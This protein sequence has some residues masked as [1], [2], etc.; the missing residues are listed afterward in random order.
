MGFF[1]RKS[2]KQDAAGKGNTP[3]SRPAEAPAPQPKTI[4][5]R[6]LGREGAGQS[7]LLQAL[8]KHAGRQ[9]AVR[10]LEDGY[11]L[12]WKGAE[13]CIRET[14]F[15][16]LQEEP[17]PQAGL[18]YLVVGL[19]EGPVDLEEEL[20]AAGRLPLRGV[21]MSKC[22]CADDDALV[23]LCRIE[24]CSC[25]DNKGI[26]SDA[27]IFIAGSAHAAAEG[28]GPGGISALEELLDDIIG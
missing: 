18:W 21:F 10:S 6:L 27:L 7:T 23:D 22:D 17:V 2:K 1:S 25:L 11:V 16:Q 4:T 9:G 20:V 5:V 12:A 14:H 19:D 13:V 8:A 26:R 24:T 3:V 15:S 28:Y